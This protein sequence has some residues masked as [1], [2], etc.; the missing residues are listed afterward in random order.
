M[1]SV[2]MV[3]TYTRVPAPKDSLA[4][5]VKEVFLK[6]SCIHTYNGSERGETLK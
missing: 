6:F 3:K 2:L 1:G 5:D 4:N